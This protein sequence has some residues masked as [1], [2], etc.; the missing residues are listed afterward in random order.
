MKLAIA[1]DL[2]TPAQNLALVQNIVSNFTPEQLKRICLKIGLGTFTAMRTNRE[3]LVGPDLVQHIR[4]LSVDYEICLDLKLFDIP[5]TMANTAQRIAEM[6]VNL[7]TVHA[8][9]G[10]T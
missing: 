2:P 7:F 3:D 9:A 10:T 5:N 1:L 6:G 4:S 8:S